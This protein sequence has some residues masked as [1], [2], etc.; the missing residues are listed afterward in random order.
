M[1]DSATTPPPAIARCADQ[2]GRMP[3]PVPARASSIIASVSMM[4][5]TRAG[6]SPS[7][8]QHLAQEEALLG[9]AAYRAAGAPAPGPAA[10]ATGGRASGCDLA[11]I[12][13]ISSV[14]SGRS[15][16]RR[17]GTESIRIAR[18]TRPSTSASTGRVG[19]VGGDVHRH[20]RDACAGRPTAAAP[21]SDSRCCTGCRRGCC[22]RCGRPAAG[23]PPR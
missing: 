19:G 20:A 23:C 5:E 18:S 17:S 15:R 7:G 6:F 10:T 14:K 13:T 2:R 1:I 3:T 8:A 22:R 12:A 9:R 11:T 16:R 4:N 21:A